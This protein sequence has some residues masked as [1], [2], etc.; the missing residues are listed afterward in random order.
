[1][2]EYKDKLAEGVE[3]TV[4][5]VQE[6]LAAF[7]G[8]E[9]LDS[10]RGTAGT[11]KETVAQLLSTE[12]AEGVK[13]TLAEEAAI[14]T[15]YK[16][17]LVG[18]VRETVGYLVGDTN[19]EMQGHEQKLYGEAEL[20]QYRHDGGGGGDT[21]LCIAHK[22]L[23]TD[24]ERTG[25]FQRAKVGLRHVETHE[26]SLMETLWGDGGA[27]TF[28]LKKLGVRELMADIRAFDARK[29][30][31]VT[32][33]EKG[34]LRSVPIGK[35]EFQLKESPRKR[36]LADITKKGTLTPLHRVPAEEIRDRSKPNLG[37][38]RATSKAVSS[39]KV[40]ELMED[41]RKSA[42]QMHL[43]HVETKDKA[44]PAIDKDVHVKEW[45]RQGFLDEVR[46]GT[47]L[48]HI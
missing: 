47:E 28:S 26:R 8:Q 9:N 19:M 24:I 42:D 35:Q 16:D 29:L 10:V 21:G 37:K 5:G 34:L 2:S 14:V 43:K 20:A 36:L 6:R 25:G 4:E 12:T 31:S 13:G 15:G 39:S 17:R 23:M 45:D 48:R 1:M 18:E 3:G 32:T 44:E 30:R 33:V 27:G 38:L 7:V 41:I 40:G 22:S 11:V 46:R